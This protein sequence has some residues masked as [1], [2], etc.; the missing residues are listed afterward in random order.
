MEE[1]EEYY[2][3][4]VFSPYDSSEDEYDPA[5]DPRRERLEFKGD[6]RRAKNQFQKNG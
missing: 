2:S 6:P 5:D 4:S 1:D 3:S